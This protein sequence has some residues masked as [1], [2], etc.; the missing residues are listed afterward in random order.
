MRLHNF[1]VDFREENLIPASDNAVDA[2][3]FDED[4][5]R[6]LATQSRVGVFGVNGGEEDICRRADGSPDLGGRPYV[7]EVQSTKEGRSIRDRLRDY[8]RAEEEV[9]PPTNWYRDHNR[10]FEN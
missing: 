3:I 6:F 5:R 8:V 7:N 2:D 10:V 1:I 9:R 4:C